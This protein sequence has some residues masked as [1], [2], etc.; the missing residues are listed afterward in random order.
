MSEIVLI[1]ICLAVLIGFNKIKID[2]PFLKTVAPE[3]KTPETKEN[4]KSNKSFFANWKTIISKLLNFIILFTCF[5]FVFHLGKKTLLFI[6]DTVWKAP[7]SP[8][9]RFTAKIN[10]ETREIK[11]DSSLSKAYKNKFK[12][13]IWRIDDGF[14]SI[15]KSPKLN[16]KFQNAGFYTIKLSVIDNFDQSDQAT[17]ELNF[18]PKKVKTVGDSNANLKYIPEETYFNYA[19]KYTDSDSSATDIISPY[20]SHDCGLS[21]KGYNTNDDTLS[22]RLKG[23][24]HD[25]NIK[26]S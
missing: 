4:S 22:R 10:W 6:E 26:K 15:N 19:K 1:I 14:S 11:L 18:P 2:L 9:A 23:F 25:T 20:V 8:V 24:L 21:E 3:A 13:F 16:Y 12:T 17:C 5:V 7:F